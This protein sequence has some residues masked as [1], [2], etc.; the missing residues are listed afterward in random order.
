MTGTAPIFKQYGLDPAQLL[1]ESLDAATA[2]GKILMHYYNDRSALD[3]TAKDDSSPVTRADKDSSALIEARLAALTPGITVVSEEN[4]ADPAP[5]QPYWS[6]DPL[7]GTKLFINKT[8]SFAVHIA[9]MLEGRPVLGV[10]HCPALDVT[11]YSYEGSPAYKQS[12]TAPAQVISG[13]KS[14]SKG[15]LKVYFDGAH[16]KPETYQVARR[17]LLSRGFALTATPDMTRPGPHNLLVAEGLSDIHVKT[18]K[19]ESFIKSSGHSWDNAADYIILKNAG[20]AMVQL[21]QNPDGSIRA[22]ELAFDNVR[23]KMPAYISFRD[24]A[25]CQRVFPELGKKPGW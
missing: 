25:L 11:Y 20:G 12:G 2:A 13:R 15:D 19:D 9:L 6:I 3:I 8:G 17:G 10:V 14:F 5:D 7:D 24:R 18:G 21:C 23:G 1:Q 16:A 22:Q 4:D